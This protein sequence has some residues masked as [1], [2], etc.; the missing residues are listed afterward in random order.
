MPSSST[1][2][3][4][5]FAVELLTLRVSVVE[6]RIGTDGL[7]PAPCR[8]RHLQDSAV[9]RALVESVV[10][11]LHH[12]VVLRRQPSFHENLCRTHRICDAMRPDGYA[13]PVHFWETKLGG[14]EIARRAGVET[15]PIIQGP[16]P[17]ADIDWDTLPERFVVK[18]IWGS[19]REGVLL[20]IRRADGFDELLRGSPMTLPE[21]QQELTT[22]AGEVIVERF[23]GEQGAPPDDW[24]CYT[25]NGN[26]ELVLQIRRRPDGNLYR[27]YDS[28]WN[29]A[30]QVE[31]G[32]HCSDE[33]RGPANPDALMDAARRLSVEATIPFV[34]V[35]LY[36]SGDSVVFGELTPRQ[37]VVH[38][39]HLRWDEQLGRAWERAECELALQR[40]SSTAP[41][42]RDAGTAP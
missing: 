24:K 26:T 42:D 6:L 39:C 27:W 28:G 33:L 41:A 17:A 35:D 31:Y 2:H 8:D 5:R 22:V 21:V 13:S 36:E 37:S 15:T 38:R 7:S 10:N 11:R 12:R 32:M 30:G 19:A 23:V 18:P 25:F 4:G 9:V 3:R 40:R 14:R 20:L 29:D 16:L 34:R 1:N